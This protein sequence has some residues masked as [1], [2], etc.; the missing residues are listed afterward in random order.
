[1]AINTPSYEEV[2]ERIKTDISNALP[3]VDPT[4]YGSF[5]RAF[6][7]SNAGRHYDNV[8]LLE[9]LLRELFPQTATGE[10]LERWAT[11]EGLSRT[12]AT[13]AFGAIIATGTASTSVPIS[14]QFSDAEGV[15]VSTTSAATLAAVSLSVSS[16]TRSGTTV[17]ATLASSYALATGLSLTI[18]GAVETAYNGAQTITVVDDDTFTYEITGTPSSPATGTITASYTGAQISVEA[19]ETGVDGNLDSAAVVSVVTPVSGLD[20]DAIVDY[21]GLTGGAAAETDDALRARVLY[22]RAH[23]VANFNIY[24]IEEQAKTVA[25]VTRVFVNPITPDVGSVTIAFMM[26]ADIPTAGE[27]AEVDAAI[28][29]IIPAQTDPDDVIV[30]APTPVTVNFTFT[31]LSPD[32]PSMRTAIENNL[33]AFFMDEVDYEIDVDEDKYRAAIIDTYDEETG[34]VLVSFTLSTPSADVTVTTD[35]IGVL[36][37]I[38]F[39]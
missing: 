35:E 24:A 14:T 29:E 8:L 3:D 32:T 4:I 20:D 16:L 15:V 12:S 17:T 18:A 13:A 27:V 39:P 30:Q 5:V 34:D 28:A 1:M 25:G 31:A 36:G 38:T 33:I 2:V 37:T 21:L 11:Y 19:D 9:Q 22:K 6:A 26:G 23:P 7:V 10:Y